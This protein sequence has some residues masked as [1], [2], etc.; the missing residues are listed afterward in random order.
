MSRYLSLL[1]D[2]PQAVPHL[3]TPLLGRGTRRA[4][5]PLP[6]TKQQPERHADRLLTGAH[7]ADEAVTENADLGS[8]NIIQKSVQNE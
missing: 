5:G 4:A 2:Q 6:T 8:G 1:W 7:F 3:A